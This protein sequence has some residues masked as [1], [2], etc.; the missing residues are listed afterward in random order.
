[1]LDFFY[2]AQITGY[3]K[4]RFHVGKLHCFLRPELFSH[5]FNFTTPFQKM[6]SMSARDPNIRTRIWSP[7]IAYGNIK[8]EMQGCC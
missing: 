6:G 3:F 8:I 4:L 1:M 2:A 5:F 7:F